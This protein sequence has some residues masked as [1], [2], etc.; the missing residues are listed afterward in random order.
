MHKAPP[1]GLAPRLLHPHPQILVPRL[2]HAHPP[3][4]EPRW[5]LSFALPAAELP[6]DRQRRRSLLPVLQGNRAFA[7][8]RDTG[9]EDD[10]ALGSGARWVRT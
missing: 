8:S 1:V 3:R 5:P 9:G 10:R 2:L 4:S 6:Q 7:P